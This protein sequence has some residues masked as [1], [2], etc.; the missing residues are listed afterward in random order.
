MAANK[1]FVWIRRLLDIDTTVELDTTKR[2]IA[3][4]E[5]DRTGETIVTIRPRPL[6]CNHHLY[7]RV[8]AGSNITR[9]WLPKEAS[10]RSRRTRVG[11]RPPVGP[12]PA[13]PG[14]RQGWGTTPR[15]DIAHRRSPFLA[16]N[17]ATQ[18]LVS[19]RYRIANPTLVKAEP[20]GHSEGHTPTTST[21]I[22]M[23]TGSNG[24]LGLAEEA[25]E[26]GEGWTA[27]GHPHPRPIQFN[28]ASQIHTTPNTRCIELTH[29]SVAECPRSIRPTTWCSPQV[30]RNRIPRGLLRLSATLTHR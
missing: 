14:T 7:P 21:G 26:V 2:D 22:A 29:R 28:P 8:S 17:L 1:I 16:T 27:Q 30:R 4:V 23:S 15:Q 9:G 19:R 10:C 18:G 5:E 20:A 25:H 24:I 13:T 12:L 3:H 11:A 6:T